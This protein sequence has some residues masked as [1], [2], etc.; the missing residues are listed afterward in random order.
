M[1]DLNVLKPRTKSRIIDIVEDVGIDVTAWK[2][3]GAAN[4]FYCYRWGFASDDRSIILLCLWF[5]D[6]LTDAAGVFQHWNF[7]TYIREMEENGGPKAGRARQVDEL[8]QDAW[9]LRVP[10]R[11]AIV[12][13]TERKKAR[14]KEDDPAKPDFRELDPIAWSVE[15]YDWDTG[16]CLLRRGSGVARHMEIAPNNGNESLLQ[17]HEPSSSQSP[18]RDPAGELLEDILA[19]LSRSDTSATDRDAFVKAR[20]GQGTF[21]QLLI[22]AWDGGCAVTGCSELAVLR[23]SHIKP[24]RDCSDFERL[25]PSNGLLLT[26]NLDALFDA[27]LISFDDDGAM[28]VSARLSDSH[29]N[30]LCA[31]WKLRVPLTDQQKG[32]LSHHRAAFKE[33]G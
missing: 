19:E 11:V 15:H 16:D 1:D 32:Y 22:E 12:D 6:C 27:R 30:Q 17:A 4:P 29:P 10:L 21:R 18:V 23:A 5:D 14:K 25:D 26:A 13:E 9:R 24:W 8:L 28:L 7:R 31:P 33:A 3:S 20:I 2:A